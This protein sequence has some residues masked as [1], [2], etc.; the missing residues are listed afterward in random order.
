MKKCSKR[1]IVLSIL[2]ARLADSS[3]DLRHWTAL[4]TVMK[5]TDFK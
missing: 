3:K 4:G 2:A 5:P 1:L